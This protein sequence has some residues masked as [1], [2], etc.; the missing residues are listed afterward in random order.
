MAEICRSGAAATDPCIAVGRVPVTSGTTGSFHDALPATSIVGPAHVLRYKVRVVNE[1]GTGAAP[2]AVET[3]AG[4]APPTLQGVQATPVATGVLIRW[5]D[6][7]VTGTDRVLLRVRRGDVA[8][9]RPAAGQPT[10]LKSPDEVLLA[11]QTSG[12]N[13]G[14]A[15][16][17]GAKAGVAQQYSIALTRMVRFGK[18]DLSMSGNPVI[19]T[20]SADAKAPP[21]MPPAGL[22]G[23]VNTLGAPEIDLVWQPSPGATAYRIF[24]AEGTG[25]PILLTG[26]PMRGLTY[27]DTDVKPGGQ[28]RYSI[29]AVDA[30]GSGGAHSSE[31]TEHVPDR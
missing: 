10:G 15:L 31:V 29:V 18:Q 19:V 30:S 26:E 8:A 24:R 17:T 11:V 16:D 4:E 20:V 3:L 27:S 6:L 14:G 22:E 28:Y 23:L 25:A 1:L 5:R 2:V 7:A 21:P 9:V 13:T 12:G